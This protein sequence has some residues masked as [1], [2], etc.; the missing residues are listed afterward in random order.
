LRAARRFASREQFMLESFMQPR[1][2]AR[3]TAIG[4]YL[5]P[6]RTSNLDKVSQFGLDE[7]FLQ[8]KL[9]IVTRA[10][11]EPSEDTSDMCVK[12]FGDLLKRTNIDLAAVEL[13]CVVTQNPDRNIPHT[14]AIVHQKLG[15]SQRCMT[16]DIS[17]GCAGYVH[18]L[19][20]VSSLMERFGLDHAL[21]FTCDPYS[22]VVD[23]NDKG[24]ALIFGDAASATYVRQTGAGYAIIDANFG[25]EPG[26]TSCLHTGDGPLVMDGA[27][28]LFHA[29]HNVPGSIRALLEQNGKKI[30]DIEL[31]LLHPGS[32]RVVDLLKKELNLPEAKVPFEIGEIGNT[33]SSS[34]PLVLQHYVHETTKSLLVLSGF[35]VGFTWGTCLLQFH[36]ERREQQA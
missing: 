19:A 8:K 30:E 20:L 2:I 33:V 17:Q 24:T 3:I 15:L 11:K 32:K 36:E 1:R 4:T 35:G 10:E 14:A 25:T 31:F 23:P 5:P 13:C 34:I 26:S 29:T 21:I 27:A 28:V 18:A 12:A 9:G 6:R 7:N 16:F 22:K